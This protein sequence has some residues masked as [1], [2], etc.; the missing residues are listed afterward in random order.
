MKKIISILALSLTVLTVQAQQ[1]KNIT[2]ITKDGDN[3]SK[4]AAN[5]LEKFLGRKVNNTMIVHKMEQ[6][7]IAN[8]CEDLKDF[9]EKFFNGSSGKKIVIPIFPL[10]VA[11]LSTIDIK[12][13]VPC[14]S[15][16]VKG[17]LVFA[18]DI[19]SYIKNVYY[20]KHSYSCSDCQVE[21]PKITKLIYHDLGGVDAFLSVLVLESL[22]N[23]LY[24]VSE[25]RLDDESAEHIVKLMINELLIDERT[26]YDDTGIKYGEVKTPELRKTVTSKN[27]D[28]IMY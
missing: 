10:N 14:L 28:D 24:Q 3:L 18:S 17:N 1:I 8:G 4:I 20:L 23:G 5:H 25:V 22:N 27:K 6:I 15:N 7:A 16:G 9:R 13:T 21:P 26:W 11:Y 2:Y 12:K 19:Y